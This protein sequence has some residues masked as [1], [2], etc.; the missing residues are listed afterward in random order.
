MDKLTEIQNARVRLEA[1]IADKLAQIRNL[2]IKAEDSRIN[3]LKEL[4]K[5]YD[6]VNAINSEMI[7]GH[8]IKLQNYEEGVETMKKINAIIQKA[9][10]IRVGQHS[11]HVI[12]HCR[13]CI[14][15]NSLEGLIKVIRTGGL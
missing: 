14:K 4:I 11:S 3:D 13:N 2:I 15:N 8:N 7:N 1:D 6:E 9:S 12:N 5:H 10:R